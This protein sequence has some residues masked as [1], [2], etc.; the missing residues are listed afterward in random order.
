MSDDELFNGLLEGVV[1]DLNRAIDLVM[2]AN[3]ILQNVRYYAKAFDGSEG[4][5]VG[6]PSAVLSSVTLEGDVQLMKGASIA[7]A[8]LKA[9]TPQ[10]LAGRIHPRRTV[11]SVMQITL[12]SKHP[13]IGG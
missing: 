4:K 13:Q 12:D 2:Q 7:L 6:Y 1:D 3:A 11:V 5:V 8:A 10:P 9:P